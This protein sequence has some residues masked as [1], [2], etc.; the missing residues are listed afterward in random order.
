MVSTVGL[1]S[2][3]DFLRDAA[4]MF[5]EDRYESPVMH[6]NKELHR[7]LAWTPALRFTIHEH[8]NVFVEPSETGPYPRILEL[9]N[10]EVRNFPQP[11]A[12]YAVCP[13]NMILTSD[14]QSNMKRLQSHGFGLIT[15][16]QDGHATQLFHASP[17]IQVIPSAE[18]KKEIKGLP[19]KIRQRASEAF[20]DYC[21][22]PVN[23]VKTVSE[24]LEGL[25]TQAG[26]EAVKK[27]YLKKTELGNGLAAALDVLYNVNQFK[28]VRA[29]IGG[30]RSYINEYRNLS[31]HWPRNAKKAHKKYADCRHAFL[32]GIKQIQRFRAAMKKVALSGNLSVV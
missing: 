14:Q 15:V 17:L 16:A 4:R 25:V 2:G 31:H 22:K 20:E 11:I 27:N 8:I 5:F 30:V 19:K 24:L 28:N 1:T 13:D 21:N 10:A 29:E 6:L 12:I 3:V 26:N 9:K 32:D 18:F 23:G 7:D